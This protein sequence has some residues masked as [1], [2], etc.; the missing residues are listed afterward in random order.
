MRTH[1]P[2]FNR[3]TALCPPYG[4]VNRLARVIAAREYTGQLDAAINRARD[5]HRLPR[6]NNYQPDER[7]RS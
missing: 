5:R 6:F 3:L 1:P 4:A 2:I 7:D